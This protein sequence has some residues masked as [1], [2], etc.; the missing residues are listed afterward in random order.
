MEFSLA[1]I[2]RIA[3][4]IIAR[5][6]VH[7]KDEHATLITF[8]G[9]LGAGK[10]TLIKEV[11]RQLGVAD[12][13]ASPTFVI[14]K[15]YAI[16]E[17]A[18]WKYLIH[19]DMYRLESADDILKLGWQDILDNPDNLVLIEWPEKVADVIPKWAIRISIKHQNNDGRVLTFA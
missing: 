3:E 6:Q 9:D 4:T 11:A 2:S 7:A 15:K 17:S 18:P 8:S 16:P 19:G 1:D 12:D 14:Y 13:L 10:T 5:A